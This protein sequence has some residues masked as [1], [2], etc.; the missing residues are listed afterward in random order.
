RYHGGKWRLAPW[1]IGHFPAHV[2]Y[3]EPYGGGMSVLLR[4]KR[5]TVEIYND[6]DRDVVTFFK[7]LRERTNDMVRAIELTPY[8]RSELDLAYQPREDELERA[9]RFYIRAWQA[10]GKPTGQWRSGW[11]YETRN[12][13]GSRFTDDWN[14]LDRLWK[15]AV[16]LKEVQIE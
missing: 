11:R 13:R 7:V 8:S 10:R 1:I 9:R 4:M 15:I 6:L 16:R 12:H 3:C 2:T 5:S 14:S